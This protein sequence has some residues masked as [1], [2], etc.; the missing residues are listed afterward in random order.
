MKLGTSLEVSLSVKSLPEALEFFNRL[1]FRKFNDPY[2]DPH[3]W[4]IL[5]D[6]VIHLGLH[7]E[8]L[9]SP[10]LVYFSDRFAECAAHLE[11]LGIPLVHRMESD[12]RVLALGFEDPNGQAVGVVDLMGQEIPAPVG[13]TELPIG[14]FGEYS[15]PTADLSRS[16]A[17]WKQFGFDGQT[18]DQPYPWGI[19]S[20]GL[21]TIRLHQTD[22]FHQKTLSYFAKDMPERIRALRE[23]GIVPTWEGKNEQGVVVNAQIKSPDGQP[24]YLF[25]GEV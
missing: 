9:P 5:S 14:K 10:S 16:V 18:Y 23:E 3:P 12:G 6:G 11:Q 2:D 1:G 7:Q 13:P 24:L 4:I 25:E 19:L 17:F 20:D 15:I 21:I 8:T 22:Q